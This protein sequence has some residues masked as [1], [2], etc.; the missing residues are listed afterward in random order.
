MSFEYID[1]DDESDVESIKTATSLI[2]EEDARDQTIV[3]C[4]EISSEVTEIRVEPI[5]T[6]EISS[7][8][9][10]VKSEDDEKLQEALMRQ[11][12][13]KNR[14]LLTL[15]GLNCRYRVSKSFI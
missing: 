3:N 5:K 9:D 7:E 8:Q 12:Q 4:T 15:S 14:F 11:S 2:S 1:G 10:S 13:C 6:V